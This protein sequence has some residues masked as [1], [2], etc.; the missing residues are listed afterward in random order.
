MKSGNVNNGSDFAITARNLTRTQNITTLMSSHSLHELADIATDITIIH[1][2]RNRFTASM[3][4][5]QNEIALLEIHQPD[6]HLPPSLKDQRIHTLTVNDITQHLLKNKQNTDLHDFL[7]PLSPN[8]AILKDISLKNLFLF[9][10]K[11]KMIILE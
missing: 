11:D 7:Q 10:A 6:L 4:E 3:H 2:G 5:I 1:N 9:L 8:Q